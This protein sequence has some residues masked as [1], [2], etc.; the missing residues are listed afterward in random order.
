L[1][2]TLRST[3]YKFEYIYI[4]NKANLHTHLSQW[5]V[6]LWFLSWFLHWLFTL[7]VNSNTWSDFILVYT[8]LAAE[9]KKCSEPNEVYNLCGSACPT[10]C[11]DILNTNL[12]KLCTLQC[13]IGCFC[14][15]GYVRENERPTSRCIKAEEC[16]A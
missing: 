2:F 6:R 16:L 11:G 15:Q 9:I 7:E 3:D 10:T 8:F 4:C 14:E 13:V 5:Y 1:L 12:P